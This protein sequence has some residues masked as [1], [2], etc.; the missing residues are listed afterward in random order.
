VPPLSFT[1]YL[2]EKLAFLNALSTQLM[3]LDW[4]QEPYIMTDWSPSSSIP[5]M[6]RL[7]VTS[8]FSSTNLQNLFWWNPLSSTYQRKTL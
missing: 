5:T 6:S 4:H 3:T 2:E 8:T 1:C 7:G